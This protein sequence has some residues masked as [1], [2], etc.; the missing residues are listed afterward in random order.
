M[1]EADAAAH[2][3][4]VAAALEAS[5]EAPALTLVEE[6][7]EAAAIAA[8]HKAGEAVTTVEKVKSIW[9]QFMEKSGEKNA[10]LL[11]VLAL[12]TPTEVVGTVVR[13]G[14]DFAFHRDKLNHEKNRR[15]VE[16][17]L[18]E[19][20]G[21]SVRVEGV[22]LE[23]KSGIGQDEYDAAAPAA[24]QKAPAFSGN[25]LEAFGGKVVG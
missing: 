4:A 9:K 21:C 19:T 12:G 6:S 22:L 20:I 11:Y 16:E 7:V 10:A 17:A 25:V 3:A 13:I 2:A 15:Q 5:A 18:C 23:V 1:P 24:E 14:F 8:D